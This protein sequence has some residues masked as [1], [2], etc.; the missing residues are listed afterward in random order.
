M[1]GRQID[2]YQL[3]G[4]KPIIIIGMHRCGTSM[5]A[6]MLNKCGVFMGA[7]VQGNHESLLFM[8]INN[9]LL[10]K[11]NSTWDNPI[12]AHIGLHDKN[13]VN[14]MARSVFDTLNKNIMSYL[15]LHRTDNV[16]K[17]TD[18]KF[19][20]GWKDPRSTFT[21]PV[22]SCIFPSAR[23][24]HITR[25]GID[26]AN[27]LYKRDWAQYQQSNN[28][29]ISALSIRKDA[30]GLYHGRRGWI[31]EQAV[32][33]WEEYTEKA[34][35]QVKIYGERALQVKFEDLL[36]NPKS[37]LEEILAFCR[38]PDCQIP[39]G[40]LDSMNAD[41]AY[42]YRHDQDLAAVATRFSATLARFGY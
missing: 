13:T 26:A 35:Q 39:S 22:W 28:E 31:L 4:L 6:D 34:V 3:P 32:T 2:K 25:H 9:D 21:L 41:R 20:W 12:G 19:P 18:M 17:L 38:Q 36:S 30:A 11:C 5:L 7:D 10:F 14:R 33:L 16:Q 40:L 15:G 23:I 42:A 37:K 8:L 29:Y 24:I 1:M 27:S